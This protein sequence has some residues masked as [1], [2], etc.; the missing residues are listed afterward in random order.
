[1]QGRMLFAKMCAV[2]DRKFVLGNLN[3]VLDNIMFQTSR[4]SL[5]VTVE[6]LHYTFEIGDTVSECPDCP[7]IQCNIYPI[8]STFQSFLLK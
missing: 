8:M 3:K 5:T 1:M 7:N 4:V 6:V 2:L